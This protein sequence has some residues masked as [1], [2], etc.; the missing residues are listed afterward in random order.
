MKR[1][2]D[3]RE[4]EKSDVDFDDERRRCKTQYDDTR[5]RN[6]TFKKKQRETKNGQ[7]ERT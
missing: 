7:L 2:E 3:G 4:G 5:A 1:R 6:P